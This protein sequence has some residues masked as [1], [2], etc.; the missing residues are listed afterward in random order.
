MTV[1]PK[2]ADGELEVGVF[3]LF[4]TQRE[5]LA[6]F[7][8]HTGLVAPSQAFFGCK[9]VKVVGRKTSGWTYGG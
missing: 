2:P 7:I 1:C 6:V 3:D 9:V 4:M 5:E 8:I